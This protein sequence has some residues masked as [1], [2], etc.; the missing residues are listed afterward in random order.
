MGLIGSLMVH[1]SEGEGEGVGDKV[2]TITGAS[3]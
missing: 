2:A 1:V 3:G